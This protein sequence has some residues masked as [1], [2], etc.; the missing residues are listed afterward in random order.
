MRTSTKKARNDE[1]DKK[2]VRV[3]PAKTLEA[4]ENQLVALAY[5]VAEEQM[6]KGTASS[7]IITEFLKRGSTKDRLEKEIME[8]NR[9]LLTAKT[10]AIKSAER[11]DA[12]YEEAINAMKRYNGDLVQ[13]KDYDD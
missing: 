11:Q 3:A 1:P 2:E 6:R 9:D 10:E 13:T 5:D 12:L 8:R 4:R 7:Q